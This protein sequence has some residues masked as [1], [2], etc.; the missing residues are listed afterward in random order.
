[1][2]ATQA[3]AGLVRP[4]GG[5]DQGS[6]A[7]RDD[8][9]FRVEAASADRRSQGIVLARVR[10]YSV[11]IAAFNIALRELPEGRVVLIGQERVL[12]EYAPV[13]GLPDGEAAAT[14]RAHQRP[15]LSSLEVKVLALLLGGHTM[16]QA[17]RRLKLPARAVAFHRYKAMEAN[18]LRNNADLRRFADQHGLLPMWLE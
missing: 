16:E 12:A 8:L 18:G 2:E 6:H 1:M 11:A 10:Y 13:P 3:T 14:D 17:G 5:Q 9:P 4:E 7:G 15:K